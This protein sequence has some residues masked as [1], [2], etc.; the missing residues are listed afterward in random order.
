[1]AI[2]RSDSIVISLG[3]FI[4]TSLSKAYLTTRLIL[5]LRP[6]SF[7]SFRFTGTPV[8]ALVAAFM[9]V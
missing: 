3:I 7:V 9:S 5:F 1:M 8:L 6:L 2:Y 4:Y